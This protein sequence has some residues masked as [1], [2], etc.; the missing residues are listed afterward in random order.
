M[1]RWTTMH[2]IA[3]NQEMKNTHFKTMAR[4]WHINVNRNQE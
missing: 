4:Q 1:P 2:H 3:L